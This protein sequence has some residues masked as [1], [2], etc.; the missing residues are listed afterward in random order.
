MN[1]AI[2]IGMYKKNARSDYVMY[3]LFQPFAFNLLA[4]KNKK[5]SS[6][7]FSPSKRIQKLLFLEQETLTKTSP[8]LYQT[9]KERYGFLKLQSNTL[10]GSQTYFSRQKVPPNYKGRVK[11]CPL[12]LDSIAS[13]EF[14]ELSY[15]LVLKCYTTGPSFQN[16][17]KNR[18]KQSDRTK[19]NFVKSNTYNQRDRFLFLFLVPS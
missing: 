16:K 10:L 3:A 11:R 8:L 2:R 15:V 17:F 7:S 6:Q 1:E 12:D 9:I 5:A 19:Q 14:L 4:Y 18:L 13:I